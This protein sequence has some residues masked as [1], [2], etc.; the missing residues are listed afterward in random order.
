[1][2]SHCCIWLIFLVQCFWDLSVWLNGCCCSVVQSCSTLCD[3]ME[4]STT[5]FPILYHL[6]ELVQTHVH[7][8]GDAIQPSCPLS[9]PFLPAFNL[10]QHQGLF[11][12]SQL[13]IS[14]GQSIGASASASVPLVNIQDWFPLG[15]T[16]L[17]LQSKGL[18]RVF[19]HHSSKASILQHS[20]FFMVQLTSIHDSWKNHSF[21]YIDL[22]RQRHVSAFWCC[23]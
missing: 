1:M 7:W 22:C 14:G 20:A 10:C 23:V 4:C 13:F 18:S 8:V 11:L 3:S 6:S 12:M 9:S 17:I 2:E 16:V 5:G 15:L 21:D 19:Q